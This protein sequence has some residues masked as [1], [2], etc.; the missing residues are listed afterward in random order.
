ME[1]AGW[2]VDEM[3][4]LRSLR[5]FTS[6]QA[7]RYD[8]DRD[9]PSKDGTSVL[10]PYL[11]IGALSPRQCLARVLEDYP[12]LSLD[13]NGGPAVWISEII[14]REFYQHLSAAF[15]K[16]S[17]GEAFIDWADNVKWDNNK[18]LFEA[19]KSGKTGFP[20]VDAA[21]RQLADT[22]WMHNRLRMIV[23]SF[24]TKDLLIDWRWGKHGS[25]KSLL[26]WIMHRITVAGSG[27][28]QQERTRNH[29]SEFSILPHRVSG[30][31]PRRLCS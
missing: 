17:R 30:L 9:F 10:S 19:W 11:A 4:I 13:G 12:E 3:S 26:I 24:L 5:E 7:A 22:G 16:I 14:W 29:T 6:G 23:A 31:I 28:R 18:D 20:I 27:Q 15:P 21:M 2:Y 25:L 8:A 1:S